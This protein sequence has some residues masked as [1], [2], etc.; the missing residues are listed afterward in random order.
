MPRKQPQAEEGAPAWMVTYGDMM[1][2]LLCFFVIIVALSEIKEEEKY[3]I[4]VKSLQE[5]FG[6]RGGVGTNPSDVP[7]D[8]SPTMRQLATAAD[9]YRLH[10]GESLDEGQAGRHNQVQSIRDGQEHRQGGV[11]NFDT[12]SAA[13]SPAVQATLVQIADRTRGFNTKIDIRGHTARA[14]LPAGSPWTDHLEL[15]LARARAVRDFLAEAGGIR[16][17][18]MRVEGAGPYEPLVSPAYTPQQWRQ[19]DRVEVIIL[20]SLVEEYEGQA[21][22]DD[23]D[24]P[25]VP[26]LTPPEPTNEVIEPATS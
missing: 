25:S 18:R 19:N 17:E 15:S 23:S 7:P 26:E 24:Q 5:T 4:I 8:V 11:V 21:A 22:P 6:Y 14:D 2:L 9:N 13:L 1:T 3:R 16:P 10:K 12:G 20:E